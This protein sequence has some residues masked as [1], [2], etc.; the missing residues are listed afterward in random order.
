M[1]NIGFFGLAAQH[2]AATPLPGP[3]LIRVSLSLCAL[4][5]DARG[6]IGT[7]AHVERHTAAW[8]MPRGDHRPSWGA[9]EITSRSM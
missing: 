9:T 2:T 6:T 3:R 1:E 4:G 5:R 7:R 8:N